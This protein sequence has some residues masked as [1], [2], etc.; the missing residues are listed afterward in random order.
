MISWVG[1]GSC[2]GLRAFV[3]AGRREAWGRGGVGAGER[4]VRRVEGAVL[5]L[6]TCL[7]VVRLVAVVLAAV[8]RLVAVALV[9][10]RFLGGMLTARM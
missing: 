2:G 10:V 6:A 9:V 5:V 8:V 7:V 4:L 1:W 3:L